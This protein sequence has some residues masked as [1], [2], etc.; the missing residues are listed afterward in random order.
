MTNN[1]IHY[2]RTYKRI[3]EEL[4]YLHSLEKKVLTSIESYLERINTKLFEEID[5]QFKTQDELY[6]DISHEFFERKNHQDLNSF[7]I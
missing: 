5:S 2:Q 6:N 1:N 7:L 4:I 3:M